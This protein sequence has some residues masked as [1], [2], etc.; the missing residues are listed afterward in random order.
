M[1]EGLERDTVGM[2]ELVLFD[3]YVGW[4]LQIAFNQPLSRSNSEPSPKT[5]NEILSFFS[6]PPPSVTNVEIHPFAP[7]MKKDKGK[8]DPSVF[9]FFPFSN[10]QR[11]I[12]ILFS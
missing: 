11:T 12:K 9:L 5:Q 2:I 3:L 8:R 1:T 6:F 10:A 4:L 7:M